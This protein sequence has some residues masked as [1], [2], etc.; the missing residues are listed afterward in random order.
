MFKV[1]LS[2]RSLSLF[3]SELTSLTYFSI[4]SESAVELDNE[5]L[6]LGR[7]VVDLVVLFTVLLFKVLLF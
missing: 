6:E 2:F 1:C 5:L 4:F 7:I 3:L